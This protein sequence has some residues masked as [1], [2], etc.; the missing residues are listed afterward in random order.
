MQSLIRQSRDYCNEIVRTNSFFQKLNKGEL[1]DLEFVYQLR[2]WCEGF[3]DCLFWAVAR[4]QDP[5]FKQIRRRHA[6]EE[7]NHPDQLDRWM[8]EHGLTRPLPAMTSEGKD[9]L[10][11]MINVATMGEGPDQVVIFNVLLEYMA[12]VTFQALIKHFTPAVLNGPYW[13]VHAEVDETH[14]ALGTNLISDDW[15]EKNRNRIEQTVEHVAYL[16]DKWFTSLT[17]KA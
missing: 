8:A 10:N 11:Y 17:V 9:L 14:A 2:L 4:N 16:A 1:N 15:L 5:A 3:I 7:G 6:M 12:L 13:H